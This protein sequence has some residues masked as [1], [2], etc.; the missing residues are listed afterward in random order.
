MFFPCREEDPAD[1]QDFKYL[2]GKRVA[3]YQGRDLRLKFSP[4]RLYMYVF[5]SSPKILIVGRTYRRNIEQR[6]LPPS[7]R[8]LH[9]DRYKQILYQDSTLSLVDLLMLICF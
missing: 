1:V 8:R 5:L 6:P 2:A 7:I 3:V 4:P 9:A